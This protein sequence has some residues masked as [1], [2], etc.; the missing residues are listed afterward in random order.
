MGRRRRG[1]RSRGPA[2]VRGSG[3]QPQRRPGEP[4]PPWTRR[5]SRMLHSGR[6]AE[7]KYHLREI[8]ERGE[9]PNAEPFIATLMAKGN[10]G[11]I[12]DAKDFLTAKVEEEYLDRDTANRIDRLLDRFTKYR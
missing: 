8:M 6:E 2:K 3:G 10:S 4:A 7:F 12:A 5:R 9:I 1:R 11:S